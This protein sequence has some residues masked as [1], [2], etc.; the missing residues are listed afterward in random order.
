MKYGRKDPLLSV[1]PL[2]TFP[3]QF[4]EWWRVLQPP[5]RGEL[6]NERPTT[7]IPPASWSTLQPS[8]DGRHCL[9]R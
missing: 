8:I 7:P 6:G 1:I 3:D 5:E 9:I 4:R 2:D